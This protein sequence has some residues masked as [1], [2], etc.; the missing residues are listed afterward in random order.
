M[1]LHKIFHKIFNEQFPRHTLHMYVYNVS[2][3][4]SVVNSTCKYKNQEQ[5]YGHVQL[6]T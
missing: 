2:K 5:N 6:I 3:I 1:D 4:V